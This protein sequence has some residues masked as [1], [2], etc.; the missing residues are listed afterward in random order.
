ML[1]FTSAEKPYV[2]TLT[3][4]T[5]RAARRDARLR[6]GREAAAARARRAGA[7]RDS[8]DVRLQGRQVGRA[9]HARPRP[10]SPAT[11]SSAA[12]TPTPGSAGPMG[13]DRLHRALLADG[14][15]DPLGARHGVL[16]AAR[17][18]ARALPPEPQHPGRPA[19]ARSRTS[20]SIPPSAWI[21]ALGSSSRS[22]T[23]AACARTLRELDGFDDDDVAVAARASPRPQGRFNAGQK[24]N[25]ALTAAF[26]L[27]FA[28]S[29]FA[30]LARR[31]RP[32]L[33][34]R[35]HDPAARLAD[36]TSRSSCSSGTSTSR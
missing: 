24:V 17:D 33:P 5:G 16:R 19:A 34:L 12:T 22:A 11:G 36:A 31:A 2:D 10:R 30:A 29:G 20:T 28:V 9:D 4:G 18:R 13:S 35:E 1:T 6:D 15:R 32:P 25:A 7:G 26:A 3:L 14:A 21:V 8:R 23:G 27:L